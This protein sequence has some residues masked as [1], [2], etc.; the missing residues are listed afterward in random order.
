MHDIEESI[1]TFE[2]YYPMVRVEPTKND[3]VH[4]IRALV[5]NDVL[6][7]YCMDHLSNICD[8]AIVDVTKQT[9]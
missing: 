2:R 4:F 7:Q 6:Y 3:Q 8:T 9:I 5:L 1:D